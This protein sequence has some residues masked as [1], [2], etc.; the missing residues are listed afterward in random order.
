MASRKGKLALRVRS[1]SRASGVVGVEI[2]EG[3]EHFGKVLRVT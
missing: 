1:S 3:L 2:M